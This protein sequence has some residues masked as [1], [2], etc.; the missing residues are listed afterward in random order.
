[1]IFFPFTYIDQVLVLTLVVQ[2]N[3]PLNSASSNENK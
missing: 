1:M 2:F 3:G